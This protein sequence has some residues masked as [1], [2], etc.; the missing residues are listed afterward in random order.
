MDAAL[1]ALEEPEKSVKVFSKDDSSDDIHKQINR[2]R[3]WGKIIKKIIKK[4]AKNTGK[5]LGKKAGEK[6]GDAIRGD[7]DTTTPPTCV[8]PTFDDPIIHC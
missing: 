2:G 4:V 3:G 7:E 6:I 1:G 5:K 8:P